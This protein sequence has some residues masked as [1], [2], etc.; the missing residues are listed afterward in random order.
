M[1]KLVILDPTV[2]AQ[3]ERLSRAPG[4]ETLAGAT[5]GLLEN[6]KPG[7]AQLLDIVGEMLEESY[8]DITLYRSRKP[9]FARMAPAEVFE[10]LS[11]HCDAVITA[12]GD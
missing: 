11:S 10:D 3:V 4:I 12:I 8:P 1:G 7:A 2:E 5:I 9:T 6:T